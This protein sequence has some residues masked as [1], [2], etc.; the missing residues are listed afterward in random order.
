MLLHQSF[1][2]ETKRPICISFVTVVI[3][4]N[5]LCIFSLFISYSAI[6]FPR[7]SNPVRFIRYRNKKNKK[8]KEEEEEKRVRGKRE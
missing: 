1:R 8:K 2:R 5:C 6:H 7:Y 4:A 3:I